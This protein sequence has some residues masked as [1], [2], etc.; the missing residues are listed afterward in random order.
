MSIFSITTDTDFANNFI[1]RRQVL[2][3]DSVHHQ[4]ITQDCEHTQKL[5]P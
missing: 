5:K 2:T 3:L 4:A 1:R